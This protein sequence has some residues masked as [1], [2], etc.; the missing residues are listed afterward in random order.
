MPFSLD[1]IVGSST[2]S[3]SDSS[4]FRFIRGSGM[5]GSEV[6]RV[7]TQGAAQIGDTDTGYRLL[8]REM[9][10]TIG[11]QGTSAAALD[12]HRDTL[13]G[14]FRPLTSTPIQLRA[15]LDDGTIRQIDCNAVGAVDIE[16]LPAHHPGFYHEA[17][18]TLRAA[19]PAW[20]KSTPGTVLSGTTDIDALWFT[21]GS[22]IPSAHVLMSGAAPGQGEA[23]SYLG[24]VE[25]GTD[26]TIV[27]RTSQPST[28]SVIQHLY[29]VSD[30]GL[31][32]STIDYSGHRRWGLKH[33]V[34]VSYED[35][36]Y[37]TTHRST[38]GE[39]NI[40][41]SYIDETYVYNQSTTFRLPDHD[42]TTR[43]I[44]FSDGE[45]EIVGST[46]RW[47]SNS[48]GDASTYWDP[49]IVLYALYSPALT[50]D[51]M[52]ALDSH[53]TH[54]S[55]GSLPASF[56]ISYAGDLPEFPVLE[57]SGPISDP[58]IVNESTGYSLN[59]GTITIADGETYVI[60]MREGRKSVLLGTVS[61][62]GDLT[63]AS[64]FGLW[65]LAPAPLAAGGTNSI[66]LYGTATGANTELK[67][68]YYERY[69]GI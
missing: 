43:G 54:K 33:T 66:A 22:A 44:Y 14:L 26:W 62:L 65:N 20:Y 19:D 29:E 50:V 5:G 23:W 68:V 6:R 13:I 59:F 47:R 37:Y 11:M 15:T 42:D 51:Q 31:N 8:P 38:G 16:L 35:G 67:V 36:R 46:G 27:V 40:F 24:T 3:L 25:G 39:F 57:L 34:E 1:A 61:K 41:H 17:K 21:A 9:T 7:S 10:L 52:N 18:V 58:I 28:G 63:N 30:N 56:A 12:A 60:D 64:D 2:V 53:M 32:F 48:A 55:S 4:P 49:A 69:M 45:K